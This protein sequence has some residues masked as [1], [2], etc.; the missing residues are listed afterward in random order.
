V[1]DLLFELHAQ[2]Q[3]ILVLATHSPDLAARFKGRR[4]LANRNLE[5]A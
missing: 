4:R 1:A 2:E 5:P 3:T